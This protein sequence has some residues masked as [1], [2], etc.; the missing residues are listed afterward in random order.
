MGR[1]SNFRAR[2]EPEPEAWGLNL[3]LDPPPYRWV[4]PA[5]PELEQPF[6]VSSSSRARAEP[7][8]QPI[9]RIKVWEYW[10]KKG[11]FGP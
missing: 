7:Q 2:A 5:K 8:A 4:E 1:A 3:R 9:T 10:V 6:Q 11:P